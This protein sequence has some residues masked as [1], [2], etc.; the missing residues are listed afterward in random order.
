MIGIKVVIIDTQEAEG[1][2]SRVQVHFGQYSEKL[3]K[4]NK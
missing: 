3:K 4:V 2:G 1:G